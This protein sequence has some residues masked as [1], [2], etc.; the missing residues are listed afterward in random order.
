LRV[1]SLIFATSAAGRWLGP[2]RPYQPPTSK[3]ATPASIIVGTSGSDGLRCGDVTASART[4]PPAMWLR[5]LP[6]MSNIMVSWPLMTSVMAGALP[7]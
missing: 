7:L 1:A 5:A 6:M 4:R 2:Y 3:P